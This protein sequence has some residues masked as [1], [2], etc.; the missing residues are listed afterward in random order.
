[1]QYDLGK[2]IKGGVELTD[3]H[4]QFI[5]YQL[6]L[7]L[8][9]IHSANVLHRD[10]VRH[11]SLRNLGTSLSTLTVPSK[12]VILDWLDLQYNNRRQKRTR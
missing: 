7:G 6:L 9:Y 2:M 8:K 11:S 1:M 4:K 10:L 3:A 5:L 12:Y